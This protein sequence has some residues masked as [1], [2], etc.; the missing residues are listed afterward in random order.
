MLLLPLFRSGWVTLRRSRLIWIFALVAFGVGMLDKLI[1]PGPNDIA[2]FVRYLI[3]GLAGIYAEAGTIYSAVNMLKGQPPAFGQGQAVI[4]KRSV[5]L[6]L[7]NAIPALILGILPSLV[8][9]IIISS[10]PVQ[11][12]F[13]F[14][15]AGLALLNLTIII[16]FALLY[17]F[18]FFCLCEVI[19]HDRSFFDSLRRGWRIFLENMPLALKISLIFFAAWVVLR[20]ASSAVFLAMQSSFGP[21]VLTGMDFPAILQHLLLSRGAEIGWLLFFVLLLDPLKRIVLAQVYLRASG[22][23]AVDTLI[24]PDAIQTV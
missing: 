10:Q 8:I 22:E 24:E 13:G 6:V 20:A 11:P 4:A 1:S 19:V 21:S 18:L 16:L 23:A 14:V 2:T 17:P 7:Y 9:S 15:S 5:R 12:G 3:V